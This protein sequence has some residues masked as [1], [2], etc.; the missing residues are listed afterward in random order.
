LKVDDLPSS[1]QRCIAAL[2]IGEGFLREVKALL[3]AAEGSK[4]LMGE[5]K[6]RNGVSEFVA[7]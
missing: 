2:A 1:E 3:K 5:S 4:K 6:T 7:L